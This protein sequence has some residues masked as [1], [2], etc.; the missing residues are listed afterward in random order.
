MT[1]FGSCQKAIAFSSEE[2]VLATRMQKVAQ[3]RVVRTFRQRCLQIEIVLEIFMSRYHT[4]SLPRLLS[5]PP[6]PDSLDMVTVGCGKNFTCQ[7]GQ[8][9]NFS[10]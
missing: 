1:W 8:L 6:S 3:V 2:N 9:L 10:R 5:L 4:P 7:E